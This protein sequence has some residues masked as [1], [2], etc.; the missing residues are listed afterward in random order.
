MFQSRPFTIIST[1]ENHEY[2][3]RLSSEML[4]S[5]V[6]KMSDQKYLHSSIYRKFFEFKTI[7]EKICWN[8]SIKVHIPILIKQI[9]LNKFTI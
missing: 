5:T 6:L 4:P 9:S 1:A 8:M 3:H 7:I 2:A